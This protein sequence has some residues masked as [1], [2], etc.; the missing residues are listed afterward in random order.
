MKAICVTPARDLDVRDIPALDAPAPGHVLIDMDSSAINHGDKAFLKMP[1]AAGH[2]FMLGQHDVWGASGSGRVVALGEGV[3]ASYAG[4]QVAIYRSLDR[5]PEGIG[6][7]SEQ[8]HVRFTNCVILPEDVRARDY[9]GSLV[10]VMTAHAFLEEIVEAG[11]S[12]VIVTA[13]NASTGHAM[14]ALA[15][16]RSLPAIF[17]VRSEVARDELREFGVEHVVVTRDG[18]GDP[19][20]ALAAELKTTAVFDGVGG[21]FLGKLAP[22]LPMNST[23]YAFGFLGGDTP[24]SISSAMLMMK[25]LTIRRFSNF[26]SRTV[27]DPARL[28]AALHYL[29][30]VIDDPMFTTKL[31]R[32]FSFDEVK[33]AM[34]YRS[35]RGAKA[36][37]VP[38]RRPA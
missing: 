28:V 12:G 23:I 6:L 34:P 15:R 25:N 7:W 24:I 9:A 17:L 29:G 16:R 38:I 27:K 10:N 32:E 33:E 18:F 14:A 5:S 8:S 11:H 31:G 26:E 30:S 2:A 3:P 21:D 36:V 37:L 4:R 22:S 19:L 35:D 1:T 13:G 20:A